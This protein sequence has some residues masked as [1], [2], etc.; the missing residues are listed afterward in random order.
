MMTS[1][2]TTCPKCHENTPFKT[3]A[4]D[5]A[6]LEREEGMDHRVNCATCHHPYVATVND[7]KAK[8]NLTIVGVSLLVGLALALAIWTIGFIAGLAFALPL[9][10]YAAQQRMAASFNAYRVRAPRA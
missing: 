10:V 6:E 7:V 1:K 5:R 4:A 3:M 2:Y 8:P 9:V